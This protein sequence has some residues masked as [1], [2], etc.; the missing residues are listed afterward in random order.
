MGLG[1]AVSMAFLASASPE[2]FLR[3]KRAEEIESTTGFSVPNIMNLAKSFSRIPD[4]SK[5]S[6][7]QDETDDSYENDTSTPNKVS[8]K[9]SKTVKSGNQVHNTHTNI[10]QNYISKDKT[11]S[12]VNE[13]RKSNALVIKEI[14]KLTSV[15]ENDSKHSKAAYS[16]ISK[17]MSIEQ[18]KMANRSKFTSGKGSSVSMNM[19]VHTDGLVN[20]TNALS[21]IDTVLNNISDDISDLAKIARFKLGLPQTKN[22]K[23]NDVLE[24]AE[25]IDPANP[26]K[27]INE[28]AWKINT[29]KALEYIAKNTIPLKN[30][31]KNQEEMY[32]KL[33]MFASYAQQ[34]MS[35]KPF[36]FLGKFLGSAGAIL[37]RFILSPALNITKKMVVGT[38]K[39]IFNNMLKPYFQLQ[40]MTLK[41]YLVEQ[42]ALFEKNQKEGVQSSIITKLSN[43]L[44]G[45]NA[46]YNNDVDTERFKNEDMSWNK[47]A[48]TSIVRVIPFYLS[49]IL[50]ALSGEKLV[51]DYDSG[52]FMESKEYFKLQE[53]KQSLLT[54]KAANEEARLLENRFLGKI[55]PL[56]DA[57]ER[58][59]LRKQ[60]ERDKKKFAQD[61][62]DDPY[63]KSF[64]NMLENNR[65]GNRKLEMQNQNLDYQDKFYKH[66]TFKELRQIERDNANIWYK[67]GAK[68]TNKAI[69]LIKLGWESDFVQG[70]LRD[71][72]NSDFYKQYILPLTDKPF[73]KALAQLIKMGD[74]GL[75]LLMKIK[76]TDFYYTFKAWVKEK[77]PSFYEKLDRFDGGF[78]DNKNL[79]AIQRHSKA[80][81]NALKYG[82][83]ITDENG[84]ITKTMGYD[85]RIRKIGSTLKNG[86]MEFMNPN[87]RRDNK[88]FRGYK[89]DAAG[90]YY[91]MEEGK[92]RYYIFSNGTLIP[93]D[94]AHN[95]FAS[96]QAGSLLDLTN[97]FQNLDA[98]KERLI[99]S[100]GKEKGT[101]LYEK[102]LDFIKNRPEFMGAYKGKTASINTKSITSSISNATSN[103]S[104]F[105]T[106]T[107]K[108]ESALKPLA[109]YFENIKDKCPCEKYFKDIITSLGNIKIDFGKVDL[110]PL[111]D[112]FSISMK[113]A[114]GSMEFKSS[115]LESLK[116]SFASQ[117]FKVN[118]S[119]AFSISLERWDIGSII[120]KAINDSNISIKMAS[121]FASLAEAGKKLKNGFGDVLKAGTDIYNRFAPIIEEFLKLLT[122]NVKDAFTG[123]KNWWSNTY[124]EIRDWLKASIS[125][126]MDWIKKSWEVAKPELQRIWGELKKAGKEFVDSVKQFGSKLKDSVKNYLSKIMHPLKTIKDNLLSIAQKSWDY[127]KSGALKAWEVGKNA[128]KGVIGWG[129]NALGI[130]KE[131]K[132]LKVILEIRNLIKDIH[133]KYLGITKG[134]TI[135][136]IQDKKIAIREKI[137]Q[138]KTFNKISGFLKSIDSTTML[139]RKDRLKN[140][141]KEVGK[142]IWDIIKAT[143][144]FLASL[145]MMFMKMFSNIFGMNG[146]LARTLISIFAGKAASG[147]VSGISN[148]ASNAMNFVGGRKGKAVGKLATGAESVGVNAVEKGAVNVAEKG[149]LKGSIKG[150]T[151][152]AGLAGRGI[153]QGAKLIP[154]VGWVLAAGMAGV[155][156]VDGWGKASSRFGVEEGSATT[157]QKVASAIGSIVT[158]GLSEEAATS[159]AKTV[160][161]IY[162]GI[163]NSIGK[164]IS[165]TIKCIGNLVSGF[166]DWLCSDKDMGEKIKDVLFFIPRA[167]STIVTTVMDWATGA[168]DYLSDKWKA[169]VTWWESPPFILDTISDAFKSLWEGIKRPFI[170]FGEWIS[171]LPSRI[172]SG[173]KDIGKTIDKFIDDKI[174]S[175]VEWFCKPGSLQKKILDVVLYIPR[176]IKT[177]AQGIWDCM[178]DKLK[179]VNV[180]N[181]MGD[182]VNSIFGGFKKIGDWLSEKWEWF[183][184][185]I[186]DWVK[187]QFF[188]QGVGSGEDIAKAFSGQKVGSSSSGGKGASGASNRNN[189]DMQDNKATIGQQPKATPSS[190]GGFFSSIGNSISN[191]ASNAGAAISSAASSGYSAF[192]G[193]ISTGWDT[194]RGKGANNPQVQQA[195]QYVSQQTGLPLNLVNRIVQ[196]ESDFDPSNRTGS[197]IGLFQMGKESTEHAGFKYDPEKLKDP[198]YNAQAFV[199]YYNKV[200]PQLTA[201]NIPI[202][203]TT[204]YL[205]HQQGSQGLPDIWNLAVNGKL[206]G[207]R[208]Y[209]LPKH[210]QANP[211]FKKQGGFFSANEFLQGWAAK[212]GEKLAIPAFG[213]V[214]TPDVWTALNSGGTITPQGATPSQQV[215]FVAN[216]NTAKPTSGNVKI[217]SAK[218]QKAVAKAIPS[219]V[220]PNS[221]D[222]NSSP[223]TT[224]SDV[225]TVI[226]DSDKNSNNEIV[227]AILKLEPYLKVISDKIQGTG[228]NTVINNSPITAIN[229]SDNK[230]NQLASNSKDGGFSQ[231][232]LNAAR[233]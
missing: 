27:F 51:Y 138:N 216:S 49:K 188:T 171:N 21:K 170:V 161:G 202:T 232:V 140:K 194:I 1:K 223:V 193:A 53:K 184:S 19:S 92:R 56:Y 8:K 106:I 132:I 146:I 102:R 165:G 162:E 105:E 143:L 214:L 141:I 79:E 85:R 41:Q 39:Y 123:I 150:G 32:E 121:I 84:N 54:R 135:A 30:Q 96:I 4:F 120:T 70:I 213:Q 50:Q 2:M 95:D 125:A 189:P 31:T 203:A 36:Q 43:V 156:A 24:R 57:K 115:L 229:K 124:P 99:N 87:Q 83:T 192:T 131:A 101:K 134:T 59:Q 25:S 196:I 172:W 198:M 47:E 157:S 104:S 181:I 78:T 209:D 37:D 88:A 10:T 208:S 142:G 226:S 178:T 89:Q 3:M 29:Y 152:T 130:S 183:K 48:N 195:I 222:I 33:N 18:F 191:F 6:G 44:A 38:G 34:Q 64:S 109:A 168:M 215:A 206:N 22:I 176:K 61:E 90:R 148:L 154:G 69:E 73:E 136:E 68:A 11:S 177:L 151:K 228:N 55:I 113:N 204:L 207:K 86:V 66:I 200:K 147:A 118:L 46:R 12:I 80:Q 74:K 71:I 133:H 179:D 144:P 15:I 219:S 76:H 111:L 62:F 185:F 233:T 159:V 205:L 77:F 23:M 164:F 186:P 122:Q 9:T 224:K 145:P 93:E 175:L 107:L 231:M 128:L 174:T 63:G 20:I 149:I 153:L 166:V 98:E 94:S 217:A 158:L 160:N 26:G 13:I 81:L 129:K 201:N 127:I 91:K 112:G 197:Y 60:G 117:E 42:Q 100:Y 139:D 116:L 126:S 218:T 137:S 221:S 40:M 211:P 119:D 199:A 82:S 28:S 182:M 173:I 103:V 187:K 210:L 97:R 5:K 7:I 212:F 75:E 227:S 190:S 114:F 110:Q 220:S 167:I 225:N 35:P 230:T 169:F 17:K 163:K 180:F 72:K 14:R 65:T 45:F 58:L 108:L 52:A 16:N 67:L 155:E